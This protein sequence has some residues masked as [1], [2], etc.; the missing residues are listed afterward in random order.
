MD[1][2][3]RKKKKKGIGIGRGSV[4]V[5]LLAFALLA[6]FLFPWVGFNPCLQCIHPC[7]NLDVVFQRMSIHY[8]FCLLCRC[9][10]GCVTLGLD[11]ACGGVVWIVVVLFFCWVNGC[12]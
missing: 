7:M 9:V 8:T 3:M 1:G 6:L 4:R 5:E 10:V 12:C 2:W 11:L